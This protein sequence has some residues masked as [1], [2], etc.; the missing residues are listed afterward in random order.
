MTLMLQ[1]VVEF[2]ERD[3]VRRLV[4]RAK[5]RITSPSEIEQHRV[6]MILG[7]A[8]QHRRRDPSLDREIRDQEVG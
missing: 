6:Q 1:Q 3:P 5:R 4:L 7:F 2:P 8:E